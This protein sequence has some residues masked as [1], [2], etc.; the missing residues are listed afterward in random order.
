M[1]SGARSRRAGRA[2]VLGAALLCVA[3][4]GAPMRTIEKGIQSNIDEPRRVVVRTAGDWERLWT[5]HA[6]ERARPEVDFGREMVVAVFLGSR[7]TAGF[8]VGI[9]G[10]REEGG[11][12]IVA[13]RETRPRPGT[14]AAQVITSPYAIAAIPKAPGDVKF[15][16]AKE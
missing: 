5:E 1:T 11:A 7:P 10:V 15:E 12:T 6:G 16:I 9:V 4:A 13:Y 3:A 8:G 14:V 2:A